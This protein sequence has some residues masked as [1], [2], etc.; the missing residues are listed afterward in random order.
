MSAIPTVAVTI[1]F[2]DNQG[3]AVEGATVKAVLTAQER[4]QGLEVPGQVQ[5]QTNALGIAVLALFPNELGSEGSSYSLTITPPLGGSIVRF[6]AIPDSACDVLIRPHSFTAITGP[7]G[8]QGS[9]GDKG[10]KGERGERG[11]TGPQGLPGQS[12]GVALA[13][14]MAA[15][16]YHHL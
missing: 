2:Q 16:L 7:Q 12:N 6:V 15:R 14:V 3:Q 1:R 10:E 8:P 4:Y 5:G 13:S 9:R 11:Q